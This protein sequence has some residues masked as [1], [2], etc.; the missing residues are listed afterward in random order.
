MIKNINNCDVIC[1]PST[2]RKYICEPWWTYYVTYPDE[3]E[4]TRNIQI[5]D[6]ERFE[7]KKRREE[8]PEII[9][10]LRY[11]FTKFFGADK[12]VEGIYFVKD[13]HK[14]DKN[15]LYVLFTFSSNTTHIPIFLNR[16]YFQEKKSKLICVSRLFKN[17]EINKVLQEI[18]SVYLTNIQQTYKNYNQQ[19]YQTGNGYK[20]FLF[21]SNCEHTIKKFCNF[22]NNTTLSAISKLKFYN[23]DVPLYC[24]NFSIIQLQTK[25]K[26]PV[27]IRAY[28]FAD[29]CKE[30]DESTM[31]YDESSTI[32]M[33]KI[34]DVEQLDF[35]IMK[36]ML[37]QTIRSKYSVFFTK[38]YLFPTI[39]SI[40][41][42]CDIITYGLA[43]Y[44]QYSNQLQNQRQTVWS[45]FLMGGC[46]D[47]RIFLW[48][49]PFLKYNENYKNCRNSSNIKYLIAKHHYADFF[50][51]I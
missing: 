12:N 5:H 36:D 44:K 28:R 50:H 8:K 26:I 37:W 22:L 35:E 16:I 19:T 13:T 18:F 30:N 15:S 51:D 20:E 43:T 33:V 7:E 24:N 49:V 10:Q 2:K 47:P 29:F 9:K 4:N 46:Y 14:I 41:N 32:L 23:D 6:I 3:Y 31:P 21:L 40:F 34:D 17:I 39:Q 42:L 38:H 48:I 27:F 25:F 1:Q 11:N 45:S